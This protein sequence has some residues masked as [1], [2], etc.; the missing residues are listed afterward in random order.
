[1]IVFGVWLLSLASCVGDDPAPAEPAAAEA[2][3]AGDESDAG[4]Q[5]SDGSSAD[6]GG[7]PSGDAAVARGDYLWTGL[8]QQ[9]GLG[10]GITAVDSSGNIIVAST[11][12]AAIT[13][14]GTTHT[15]TGGGTAILLVKLDPTGQTVL[16]AQHFDAPNGYVYAN[17]LGV[18]AAGN[19]YIVGSSTADT[20][21]FGA[22]TVTNPHGAGSTAIFGY[23]ASFLST[24]GNPRWAFTPDVATTGDGSCYAL[25]T[26]GPAGELA[27]TCTYMVAERLLDLGGGTYQNFSAVGEHDFFVAVLDSGTG[28]SIW[29]KNYGGTDFERSTGLTR[30]GNN[31]L[32]VF[33]EG[34]SSQISDGTAWMLARPGGVTY[35]AFVL[36][37]ASAAGHAVTYSKVIAGASGFLQ[38]S[39]VAVTS[40][41]AIVVCGG[42]YGTLDFGK[43][44][45]S[46]VGTT[47]AYQ[48]AVV[49]ALDPSNDSTRWVL[50]YGGS[51]REA[52][53]GVA[54]DSQ[55]AVVVAGIHDSASL[56]VGGQALA[57]PP[58]RGAA[59]SRAGHVFKMDATGTVRWV[60]SVTGTGLGTA[61]QVGSVAIVPTSNR[62]VYSGSFQGDVDLGNGATTRSQT[63]GTVISF[64]AAERGP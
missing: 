28:K 25:T 43:G 26:R 17:D 42:W 31:D 59:G 49:F 53:N 19:I 5:D 41:G 15:P 36:R 33:G 58:P 57:D 9:V 24:S 56:T 48:D 63:N 52:C 21:G 6:G 32:V 45:I 37:I 7:D 20:L 61:D 39:H 27:I 44:S 47:S 51:Y 2:G 11:I 18:D 29:Y 1:M 14:G 64:F 30:D 10:N 4:N 23:A 46:S 35:N 60:Y 22:F 16:W 34:S 3:P 55:G 54:A 12:T 13:I 38:D 50:P 8:S 62:V 40:D